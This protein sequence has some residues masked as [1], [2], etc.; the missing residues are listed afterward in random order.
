VSERGESGKR[1]RA[2]GAERKKYK[3][4][5]KH[6]GNLQKIITLEVF[7]ISKT[8]ILKLGERTEKTLGDFAR[9]GTLRQRFGVQREKRGTQQRRSN[10]KGE[11]R[12]RKTIERHNKED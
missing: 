1:R 3:K 2:V 5:T 6:F 4:Q 11:K 12:E 8:K 9:V 7:G 10:A